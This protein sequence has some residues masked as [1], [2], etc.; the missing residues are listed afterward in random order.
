MFFRSPL[1]YVLLLDIVLVIVV[2]L[3]SIGITEPAEPSTIITTEV[4]FVDNVKVSPFAA[5]HL[6]LTKF[7]K[8]LFSV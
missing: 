2:N 1:L 4:M 5:G 7:R 3:I 6:I 8:P